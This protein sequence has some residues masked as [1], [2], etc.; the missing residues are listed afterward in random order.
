MSIHRATTANASS[1]DDGVTASALGLDGV[2]LQS[3]V[4]KWL[5]PLSQWP[6]QIAN[7]ATLGY[8]LIH[9]A[10]MQARGHSNSP[11]S[12]YD[13]LA[14]ADDLFADQPDLTDG[15]ARW[16]ALGRTLRQIEADDG[17]LAVA[18]VVLN[19]TADNSPWLQ[20]HPESGY[21]LENAPHLIPAYELDEALMQLSAD[22][23]TVHHV[24]TDLRS[25][26]DLQ[27]VI[28]VV[29]DEVLAKLKLWEYYIIDV[30]PAVEQCREHMSQTKNSVLSIPLPD[31]LAQQTIADLAGLFE[32]L[33][34]QNDHPGRRYGK[35]VNMNAAIPFVLA[36][37]ADAAAH[38]EQML[39]P[40]GGWPKD[41]V[42]KACGKLK[43]I[44]EAVNLP[45]YRQYDA[46]MA[47]AI[48][49]ITNTLRYE[50]L[51]AH[52]PR[53]GAITRE[54]PLVTTYFTRLPLNDT[55]RVHTKEA[56][57]L[58][59]NGWIW[60]GNPLHD[61]A[62]AESA[63]YL[64][65]DVIVW[66]DCVKLRYGSSRADNPWLWDHMTEYTKRM[67][68][69]FHGFR[70]DNC[71]STPL[72][73]AEHVLDAARTVRPDL[74]VTAELFT[75]DEEIDITF[76]SRLGIHS[77]VRESMRADD[78]RELSRLVHRY[79]GIPIGSF[80]EES[81][82]IAGTV[83]NEAGETVPCLFVPVQPRAPHAIF[84]DCT[85]DNE[86][87][88]QRRMTEDTLPNAAVVS[89]AC[90]ATGSVRGYDELF[91]KLLDLVQEQRHYRLLA[92]PL[93]EGIGHL[94]QKLQ[95]LHARMAH[96]GCSEIFV[97]QE[98]QYILVHRQNPLT[99]QGYLLIA[100]AYF[101]GFGEH[102]YMAPTMLRGTKVKTLFSGRI[103]VTGDDVPTSET[104]LWGIPAR[105]VD[106]PAL[107]IE[108]GRDEHGPWTKLTLPA[109]FPPGSIVMLETNVDE[110]NG[111]EEFI[112]AEAD[113][114]MRDLTPIELNI[115]LYRCG[116]E[117]Q[118]TTPGNDVYHIPNYGALPYCGLEGFMSVLRSV[119]RNNDLGHALCDHLRSGRW[120]LDYICG[121]I[122]RHVDAYPALKPFEQWLTERVARIKRAPDFL[123]P[124]LFSL[125]VRTAYNAAVERASHEMTPMVH[126]SEL[127]KSLALCSLQMVGKVPST[128]LHPTTNDACLAAGLTHFTVRHMR[129]WGRDTFIALHGLLVATGRFDVA[130]EHILAF[131]ENIRHG[132]I[133]NLLD[134]ARKPRYNARDAAWWFAQAVKD[135]CDAAP[136]GVDLLQVVVR[137]RFPRD[138][139][140]VDASSEEAYVSP[141]TLGEILHEICQRHAN[142]IHFR[143]W[144]AGP[145]LDHAMQEAGFQI[146]I[147][148][149]IETGLVRGGNASN[150]GTWMDKMGDSHKAGNYGVPATPRDG[151]PIEIIGLIKSTV[152][153][154][155]KLHEQGKFPHKGVIITRPNETPKLFAY[156]D[157][158]DRIQASFE[159]HFYVPLHS[160]DDSKY[161][162]DAALV[163]RRGI[164]KDTY[165]GSKAFADYQFRPNF[166]VAMVVAP[167][168]FDRQHAQ[169]V[170]WQAQEHLLGPIGMRTL[171]P[172]DWA[173]RGNY[174]NADDSDD[175]HV[176]H[177]F[178][179]HQ[180]P[181]WVWCTG[182]FLRALAQFDT[183]S[184][185]SSKVGM[186]INQALRNFSEAVTTNAFAGLPELTNANGSYCADSCATQAWS[187][188]TIL[189]LLD[190]LIDKKCSF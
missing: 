45:Y 46:D 179:Y 133:P 70:L 8:N 105:V 25:E 57:V 35:E 144:N 103:E 23:S 13:Q 116:E 77:L 99:R 169:Q 148:T 98:N 39:S 75:G 110:V 90:C 38:A 84:M 188:G 66:G 137:R 109:D 48:T 73:L 165:G 69:H 180:G 62:S 93:A 6:R 159:R 44:V 131:A 183:D 94:K 150:C 122:Q 60:G 55:T 114:P 24:P 111:L 92:N 41:I 40:G 176:A 89:M 125:L 106:V 26:D 56:R 64:R 174:N 61:F 54:Q 50:R 146:D 101:K 18:D 162:I 107:S 19:H 108:E 5:G 154:L 3:V 42:E 136:E 139:R 79:G 118:D 28:A 123:M 171:D 36:L 175:V 15:E 91:P 163:N 119:L 95:L 27:A 190:Q 49:N 117:E 155:S 160:T 9:Y 78:V 142:G 189:S 74:Y 182:Y 128:G 143:E 82:A 86:T 29:R 186:V 2:V 88:H 115:V 130:R 184:A 43:E 185:M 127:A 172:S 12:I 21:N 72:P 96:D 31:N 71:H 52:G 22:L 87:P 156:K 152:T 11:Y 32:K 126:K 100:H 7:A 80:D 63:A 76:V 149:D 178:N 97:H 164:Y 68:A 34:V 20:T 53:R 168:L 135:Y 158:C 132:L 145:A 129:C 138:D 1:D 30:E 102:S 181:E 85:H 33:A 59:N 120:A 17:V 81:R 187:A 134:S 104:E 173:Y 153:W 4:P 147:D 51:D 166:A 141:S 121:R 47:A 140:Y 16:Q 151:A 65:R 170:L 14:L 113:V 58:A 157:W 10:P 67:A 124:K 83:R 112:C 167:E 161:V 177:G 37:C